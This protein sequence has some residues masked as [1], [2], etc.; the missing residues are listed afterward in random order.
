[1]VSQ[2]QAR[3]DDGGG[4]AFILGIF[5]A[6]LLAIP[7]WAGIGIAAVLLFQEGPV[8]R[9]QTAALA[10]AAVVELIL[11]RYA[12]RA[13]RPQWSFR[14]LLARAIAAYPARPI[15][16]QTALLAGLAV[17]Y[18]HYYFWDVQLQIATLNKVSVF[19]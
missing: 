12:W 13:W 15:L 2:H 18:L 3:E 10:A 19:I 14:A 5:F 11:L 16:K 7:L 6:L 4:G 17:A 9:G 1:M 8:T